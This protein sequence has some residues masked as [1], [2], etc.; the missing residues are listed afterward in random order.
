[1][2]LDNQILPQVQMNLPKTIQ[3]RL[4]LN[5]H[6]NISHFKDIAI[7]SILLI[8][9]NNDPIFCFRCNVEHFN[10]DSKNSRMIKRLENIEN[11]E[12]KIISENL[13]NNNKKIS[14][15]IKNSMELLKENDLKKLSSSEKKD[16]KEKDEKNETLKPKSKLTPNYSINPAMLEN[17]K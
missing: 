16:D 12:N 4:T 10:Y 5:K 1:M 14:D 11:D 2:N 9:E 6:E 17:V 13:L 8:D 15:E 3:I 7:P